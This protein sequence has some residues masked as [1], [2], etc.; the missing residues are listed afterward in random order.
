VTARRRRLHLLEDALKLQPKPF[1]LRDL[2]LHGVE[3]AS[4]QRAQSGAQGGMWS[5]V[6]RV[7]Q[8]LELLKREPEGAR[9]PNEP[10]PFHAGLIVDSIARRRTA[11]GW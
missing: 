1:H 3:L 5:A 9:A 8:R 4:N 7:H 10:E 6:K 11:R 2:Q